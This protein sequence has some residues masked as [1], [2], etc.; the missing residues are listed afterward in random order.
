MTENTGNLENQEPNTEDQNQQEESS[1][2]ANLFGSGEEEQNTAPEGSEAPK[3]EEGKQTQF[4]TAE[5]MRNLDFNAVD[6]SRIPPE[7]LPFYKS[8]QSS[9]TKT[10]QREHDKL[11]EAANQPNYPANT[12]WFGTI[13]PALQL[14]EYSQAQQQAQRIIADQF[15]RLGKEADPYDPVYQLAVTNTANRLVQQTQAERHSQN[16]HNAEM[17]R[18]YNKYGGQFHQV[19]LLAKQILEN[20]HPASVVNQV[21]EAARA[22]NFAPMHIVLEEAHKRLTGQTTPPPITQVKQQTKATPPR[23]EGAGNQ[24]KPPTYKD[25][26]ARLFGY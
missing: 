4:Y 7:H 19:D 15:A 21:Y 14:D 3:S 20:E 23:T 11:K 16:V 24:T 9:F 10:K 8:M 6:T 12:G 22:G 5:E 26:T 13:P 18:L 17:S 25:E 1:I 2:E